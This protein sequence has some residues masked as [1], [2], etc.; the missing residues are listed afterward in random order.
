MLHIEF[1]EFEDE[2]A[3]GETLVVAAGAAAQWCFAALWSLR[4]QGA[5][6]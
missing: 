2:D 3:E 5:L 6:V 1:E 4:P